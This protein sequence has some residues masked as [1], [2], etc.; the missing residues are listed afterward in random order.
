MAGAETAVPRLVPPVAEP[1]DPALELESK[2][3]RFRQPAERAR[4]ALDC[5]MEAQAGSHEVHGV[6]VEGADASL[7]RPFVQALRLRHSVK[8]CLVAIR[9][10]PLHESPKPRIVATPSLPKSI[11]RT[12]PTSDQRARATADHHSCLWENREECG[13]GA[14]PAPPVSLPPSVPIGRGRFPLPFQHPMASQ[15][16]SRSRR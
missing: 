5:Q 8:S 13:A 3:L 7:L 14:A 11:Q 1:I 4:S 16:R 12:Y 6:A 10:L 2:M 15:P 9:F